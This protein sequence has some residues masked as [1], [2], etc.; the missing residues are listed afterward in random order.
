PSCCSRWRP[1]GG[2]GSPARAGREWKLLVGKLNNDVAAGR[3]PEDVEGC[4]DDSR[5][6]AVRDVEANE[7]TRCNFSSTRQVR[8]GGVNL[9]DRLSDVVTTPTSSG[10]R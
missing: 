1:G 8:T 6:F 7:P 10:F 2:C 3:K 9:L 5:F 4:S